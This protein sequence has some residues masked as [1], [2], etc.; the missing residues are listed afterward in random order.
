[1]TIK[2]TAEKWNHT[3]RRVQKICQTANLK[4]Y[5]DSEMP[6][7]FQKMQKGQWTEG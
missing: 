2:E 1:M 4:G 7:W 3:E 5:R 6:R